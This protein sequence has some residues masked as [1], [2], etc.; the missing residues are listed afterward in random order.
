MDLHTFLQEIT[1]KDGVSGYEDRI[2]DF[3][4]GVLNLWLMRLEKI[5]W[6]TIFFIRREAGKMFPG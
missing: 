1:Q 4:D 5:T 3:L 2:G 6:E